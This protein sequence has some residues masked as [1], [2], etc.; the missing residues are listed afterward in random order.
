MKTF[1]GSA[2]DLNIEEETG[3]FGQ[4]KPVNGMGFHVEVAGQ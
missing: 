1:S 3:R 4:R 2:V